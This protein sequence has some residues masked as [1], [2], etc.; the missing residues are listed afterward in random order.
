M[1]A[2]AR[3]RAG[4]FRRALRRRRLGSLLRKPAKADRRLACRRL[5]LGS[6][7][8]RR[9]RRRL[10][11]LGFAM[12]SPPFTGCGFTSQSATGLLL[13]NTKPFP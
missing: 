2:A 10:R 3:L 1:K 4:T 13:K 9:A 12:A 11:R 8:F 7:S 5:R 6:G